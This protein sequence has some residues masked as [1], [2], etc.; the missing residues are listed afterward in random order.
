MNL[1]LYSLL[2]QNNQDYEKV[3]GTDNVGVKII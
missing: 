3:Y 1:Y 2:K